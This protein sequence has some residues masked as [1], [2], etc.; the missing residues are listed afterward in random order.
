MAERS[1][2]AC[3][4]LPATRRSAAEARAAARE[5]CGERGARDRLEHISLAVTEAVANTV[6]HAYPGRQDGEV[7]V[8]FR[9][10][11]EGVL[12]LSV[13]DFGVGMRAPDPEQQHFGL[14]LIHELA[15]SADVTDAGPGTLI[16]MRFRAGGRGSTRV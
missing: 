7:V 1:E 2:Q 12:E 14:R 16:V 9:M 10:A 6:V 5:W 11:G 13:R 8:R 3:L 4:R 15:D